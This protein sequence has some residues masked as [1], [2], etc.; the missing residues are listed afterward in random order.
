MEI[1]PFND[2]NDIVKIATHPKIWNWI[3]DAFTFDFELDPGTLYLSIDGEGFVSV[4]QMNHIC[5]QIHIALLPPLWGRGVEV[6]AAVKEWIFTL[7]P[8]KKIVAI[9]PADN[10]LALRL[11]RQCGMKEEGRMVASFQ[12]GLELID[13]VFFGV[14]REA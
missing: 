5:Y 8:C 14:E 2:R 9:V 11:A 1:A 4:Q 10:R 3:S 13:Q 6:G 12:R 7:T